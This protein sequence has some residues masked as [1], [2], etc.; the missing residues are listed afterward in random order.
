M[1]LGEG[2]GGGMRVV[3]A[4]KGNDWFDGRIDRLLRNLAILRLIRSLY[5]GDCY[6]R[7]R[8]KLLLK[9]NFNT[10][11]N[12]LVASLSLSVAS[13]KGPDYSCCV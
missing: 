1:C 5:G 3:G 8:L 12:I 2:K 13:K 4:K 11:I 6:T 9:S 10:L 7:T